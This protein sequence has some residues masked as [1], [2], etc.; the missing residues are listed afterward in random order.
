MLSQSSF[1]ASRVEKLG[2]ETSNRVQAAVQLAFLRTPEPA[3]LQ[4]FTAYAD[5]HGLAALCR[6]LFN[7]NEFMFIP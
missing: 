2:S 4:S 3:E 1:F 5:K 6:I 7:S